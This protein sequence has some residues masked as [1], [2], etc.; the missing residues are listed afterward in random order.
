MRY[1][2]FFEADESTNLTALGF[3]VKLDQVTVGVELGAP[4]NTTVLRGSGNESLG[5][6]DA[7]YNTLIGYEKSL[8]GKAAF[9]GSIALGNYVVTKTTFEN[10]AGGSIF[11]IANDSFYALEPRAAL[12]LNITDKIDFSVFGGILLGN[13][14][15]SEPTAGGLLRWHFL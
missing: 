15:L 7:F 3:S 11:T 8:F 9:R 1:Y 6:L 14:S 10:N 5:E 12:V 13:D 4:N 2:Q